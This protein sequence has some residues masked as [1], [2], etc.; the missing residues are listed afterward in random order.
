M[1]NRYSIFIICVIAAIYSFA[2]EL[3]GGLLFTSSQEKVDKRTSLVVFANKN[4]QFKDS[5]NLS[6]DL[7]IW[8]QDHFGH[9]FRIINNKRQ[10]VE[11][12]FV[13]FYGV[14]NMYL[15]FHSPITHQSVKI[16]ISKDDIEK[17]TVIP[18]QFNFNLIEDKVDIQLSNDKYVCESVGLENP[19]ELQF[20]F[21]LYGLNLDVPQMIIKNLRISSGTKSFYFPLNESEGEIAKDK[22]E[23]YKASVKNPNWVINNHFFWQRKSTLTINNSTSITYD[24]KLNRIIFIDNDSLFSYYPRYDRLDKTELSIFGDIK[25]YN[26]VFNPYDENC[27]VF[28]ENDNTNQN[29]SLK[30]QNKESFINLIQKEKIIHSNPFFSSDGELYFFG[31]YYNHLY[32]NDIVKYNSYSKSW[33]KEI[34]KGDEI[35]PRF[36]SAVGKGIEDD[37]ILLFGGFGNET[38]RQE[39]GGRNLYDLYS[40][41]LKTKSIKYLWAITEHPK[42]EFIAGNNL[43]LSNDKTHFYAFCYAHHSPK[44]FG[45]LYSFDLKSGAYEIMSDSIRFT[46][47]DMSTVVNLF[48][49]NDVNEFYLVIKENIDLNKSKVQVFAL[50]NPPISKASLESVKSNTKLYEL[51]VISAIALVVLIA[52]F[53]LILFYS[54]KRKKIQVGKEFAKSVNKLNNVEINL[55]KHKHSAV[56][57]F[58]NFTAYDRNGQDISHRFGMK[59]R[60]L[61]SLILLNTDDETGITTETLTL[62]LWPD[63]DV[64]ESKNIRGVTI[65]RLRNILEDIEGITLLHQNHQWRFVFDKPFY[66]DYIAY[67]NILTKIKES[68]NQ[69]VI[70][71][72]MNKLYEVLGNGTFLSNV[73]ESGIDPYKSS[74]EEKIS[75]LLK[76][77]I[78]TLYKEKKYHDIIKFSSLFFAHDPIDEEI[79]DICV[80]SYK[81]LGKNHEA[82]A[83]FKGYRK[84]YKQM[85]GEDLGND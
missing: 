18:I 72:N 6:F 55:K 50:N 43:I 79:F 7:S 76:E 77:Y 64:I 81:K 31:G 46:S 33:E 63:K 74:E 53:Y 15:D 27:Y 65:N 73:Q 4:Q 36:Y 75:K 66:C 44:T 51:F 12:V 23:K 54:N 78:V 20:A 29:K 67:N 48:F 61:F 49:N 21:G 5:F 13:N 17:K 82:K 19:S 30:K 24:E 34:F 2:G 26:T 28:T 35:T 9:V 8:D 68:P 40:I 41:N 71:D 69:D 37:E 1:N 47:E 80:K 32:L 52:V 42:A 58:G 84:T 60:T 83:F 38:G 85:T 62:S 56:Y 22:N 3:P 59:L 57:T 10:E 11:F 25:I 39:H 70:H 16:P 45:F 14:D